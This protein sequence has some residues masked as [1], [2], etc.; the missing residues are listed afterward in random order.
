MLRVFLCFRSRLNF[1]FNLDTH[2]SLSFIQL[3]SPKRHKSLQ[4]INEDS[5][6]LPERNA[7]V[8]GVTSPL[9]T[10]FPCTFGIVPKSSDNSET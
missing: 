10:L 7:L 1:S 5:F 3:V 4:P 9:K 8:L 2:G 6:Y